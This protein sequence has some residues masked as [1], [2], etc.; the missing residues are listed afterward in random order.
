MPLFRVTPAGLCCEA[1]DFYVDPWKPVDRA[2]VTHAHAD[3]ARPGSRRF[4]AARPGEAIL[5]TRL[6]SAAAIETLDYGQTADLNGVRVSLHPAGHVL[7]SAQVRAEYRGETWVISGDY[8]VAPDPT[9]TP[10]EPVPCHTFVTESTFGLP[11]Y[12]WP[13]QRVVF[14]EINRWWRANQAEGL[15]TLLFGYALGKA[16]RLL[17][18]VDR[19]IGPLYVHGAVGV[20][21]RGY[22]AGGLSLPETRYTGESSGKR[23]WSDALVIAPP[24][25]RG[26]PWLRRFGK[27]SAGFASGWMLLRGTR[28]RRAVDRGFALSDHA[29][30]PELLQ[31]ID[32]TCAERVLVTHGFQ[33]PL[34]RWLREQGLQ[35]EALETPFEGEQDDTP[36]AE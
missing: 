30:W 36:E 5:R 9:C 11:I 8:K 4:L 3:H 34:V 19:S 18:G 12:R 35:A 20:V 27:F 28:R 15:A 29:D 26:T 13:D 17:A 33:R 7:G 21:N 22:E 1:G 23:D 6:G 14:G 10:F 24:S 16:Q 32:A 31:V 25:A 2:V